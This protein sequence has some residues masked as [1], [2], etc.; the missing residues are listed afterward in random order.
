MSEEH[1]FVSRIEVMPSEPKACAT[2]GK[3]NFAKNVVHDDHGKGNTYLCLYP[4][5]ETLNIVTKFGRST[6]ALLAAKGKNVTVRPN[7]GK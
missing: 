3:I 4:D 6:V 1:Y 2:C 5:C 7:A